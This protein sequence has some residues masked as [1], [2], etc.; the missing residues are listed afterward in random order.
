MFFHLFFRPQHHLRPK[1]PPSHLPKSLS[2]VFS[3]A[4]SSVSVQ[5]KSPVFHPPKKSSHDTDFNP[6]CKI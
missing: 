1:E 2:H 3:Q 5:L 4:I 6:D